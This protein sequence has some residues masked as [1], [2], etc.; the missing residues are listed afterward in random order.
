MGHAYT[1]GLSVAERTTIRRVRRLPLRGRVHVRPGQAVQAEDVVA[2][3]EL[4][5]EIRS[6]NVAGQLGVAPEELPEILLKQQGEPVAKDEP[7]ARTRGLFGLLRSECRSPI[8]GTIESASSATGQVLIR[9]RPVA[10]QKLAY[11]GGT[12][13]DVQEEESA[14]IEVQA[15]FVE[16]IFGLAGEAI[17]QL[18]IGVASPDDVL[19][20]DRVRPEQAGKVIVGG[21]LVTADA[22]KAAA[23][24]GVKGIVSGGLNDTDV[25]AALGYELGVAITGEEQLGVTV[26]ITEGFGRIGMAHAT[27]ELLRKHSGRRASI[28]G[29]TQIRAG[30]IRPEII[31]PLEGMQPQ[32]DSRKNVT[33]LLE[34]GTRLRAIREPYFG[35]LGR[36]VAL[37]TA[38]GTLASE[39]RAR[40][41]EIEFDDGER[42]LLPRANV[43]LINP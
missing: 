2:E 43:E 30:V 17:G 3:A 31:I 38:L 28:N 29:T 4:P 42:A 19:D 13:V 36:C 35:R 7:V 23:E 33:G 15:A 14:T 24:Y 10:L 37:P 9:G 5:G 8:D 25:R 18:E 39:A 21:S 34:A 11:V 40:V 1:P 6:I 41:L 27:F 32:R 12:V 22:I 26:I 20:A 16:G